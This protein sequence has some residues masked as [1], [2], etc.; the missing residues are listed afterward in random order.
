MC[1]RHLPFTASR[2]NQ[3][4]RSLPFNQGPFA[5]A[6]PLR[7]AQGKANPQP[8][9]AVKPSTINFPAHTHTYGVRDGR[10]GKARVG[11]PQVNPGGEIKRAIRA[12]NSR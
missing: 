8:Q 1:I 7:R 3:G 4:Q 6:L 12:G 9:W 5:I 11:R 10:Q 2:D